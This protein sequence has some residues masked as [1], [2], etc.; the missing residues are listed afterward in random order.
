M[1]RQCWENAM[2]SRR[3]CLD[4][5]RIH[6]EVD[7]DVLEDKVLNIFGKIGCDIPPE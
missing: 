6:S 4:V 7:T 3:E 5:I 2:Y 1:E